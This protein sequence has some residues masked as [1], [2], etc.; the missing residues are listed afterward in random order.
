MSKVIK[1][2]LTKEVRVK[3]LKPYFNNYVNHSDDSIERLKVWIKRVGYRSRIGVDKKNVIVYGH[4]RYFAMM[5]INP[6]LK[7]PVDD[8]SDLSA[9]EI[10]RLRIADNSMKTDDFDADKLKVEIDDIVAHTAEN[11]DLLIESLE[12]DKILDGLDLPEHDEE[13]PAPRSASD[14][15]AKV[16]LEFTK[17]DY[18]K[19]KIYSRDAIEKLSKKS[20]NSVSDLFLY[21]LENFK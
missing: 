13:K 10:K 17:K 5:L 3:D 11:V 15:L 21:L 8:L 14:R 2:G 1:I 4:K 20:V 16:I 19:F 6:D 9:I 18:D 7:I 12:I